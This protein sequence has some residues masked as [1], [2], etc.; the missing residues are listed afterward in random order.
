MA[1]TSTP[2]KNIA[3]ASNN[4]LENT[5]S[6]VSTKKSIQ[7]VVDKLV[8]ENLPNAQPKAKTTITQPLVQKTGQNLP[9]QVQ[10]VEIAQTMQSS[11]QKPVQSVQTAIQSTNTPVIINNQVQHILKKIPHNTK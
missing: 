11:P 8:S 2:I 9:Q 1:V 5:I 4:Q 3:T 7:K 10:V 6:P